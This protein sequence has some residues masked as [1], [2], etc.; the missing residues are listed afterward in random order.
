[1]EAQRLFNTFLNIQNF[2][3]DAS[4]DV[5]KLKIITFQDC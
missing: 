5:L 1:M 2:N 4:Q 3:F